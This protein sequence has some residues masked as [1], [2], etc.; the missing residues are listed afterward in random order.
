VTELLAQLGGMPVFGTINDDNTITVTSTLVDGEYVLM[1]ENDEGTLEEIGTIIVGDGESIPYTNVLDEVGY[2]SGYRINSSGAEVVQEGMCVTG[3]IPITYGILRAK[4]I[5]INGTK[6]GYVITYNANKE[7]ITCHA[8]TKL[9][10]DGK[11]VYEFAVT[12]S[13]CAFIRLSIGVI[14]DTSIITVNEEIV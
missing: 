3:Y 12:E 8:T 11:G 9:V 5:T 1:Y 13:T 4:S 10:D 7:M 2:T 6:T 14:D